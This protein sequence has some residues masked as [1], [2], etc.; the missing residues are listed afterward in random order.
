MQVQDA[1]GHEG[2]DKNSLILNLSYF[3]PH[4]LRHQLDDLVVLLDLY[5]LADVIACNFFI[6]VFIRQVYV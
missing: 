6:K 5:L 1:F 2:I 3:F 4:R